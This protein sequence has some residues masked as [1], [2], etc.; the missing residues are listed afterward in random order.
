MPLLPYHHVDLTEEASKEGQKALDRDGRVHKK[1]KRALVE[2]PLKL[3]KLTNGWYVYILESLGGSSY[4]GH[5]DDLAVRVLQHQGELNGGAQATADHA[6]SLLCY[7]I[8]DSKEPAILVENA[9]KKWST[10]KAMRLQY[11]SRVSRERV[12]K[13][14][15]M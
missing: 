8:A 10:S 1:R 12:W 15:K 6:W 13:F 5:T 9:T 2:E 3:P 4:V 7:A 11:L 14:E